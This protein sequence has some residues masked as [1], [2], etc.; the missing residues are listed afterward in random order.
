MTN[1]FKDFGSGEP[2]NRE[3]IVFKLHGEEFTCRGYI[4][5]K[6]LLGLVEAASDNEG[7]GAAGVVTELFK[8][9]MDEENYTRFDNLINDPNRYVSVD[10][11][12]EITTWLVEQYSERP[13][14]VS[15]P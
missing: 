5:G 2:P 11:L 7:A 15:S 6:V 12:A 4:Q 1:R 14:Q 10:M 8:K 13:T 9:V 3:P